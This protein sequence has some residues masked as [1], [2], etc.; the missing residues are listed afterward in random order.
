MFAFEQSPSY[1]SDVGFDI[2]V[3]PDKRVFTMTFGNFQ[4]AIPPGKSS[5]PMATR[6]FCVALPIAA[7]AKGVGG[8]VEIAFVVSGSVATLDGATGSMIFSVNGQTT[9]VDFPARSDRTF[10][11]EFTFKA[12]AASEC[13]L[14]IVLL[15]GRDFKD[16]NAEAYLN[17]TSIN[18]EFLPRIQ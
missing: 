9:V 6:L 4:V 11:H 13:R 17:V 16:S 8:G 18:A 5:A 1:H 15:S 14:S 3:S 10:E 2:D 12:P 7:E